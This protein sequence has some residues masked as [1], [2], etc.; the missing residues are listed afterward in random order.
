MNIIAIR[1]LPTR[2]NVDG[3]LQGRQDSKILPLCSEQ[4]LMIE[5]NLKKL[6]ELKPF[7]KVLVSSLRRTGM[8]ADCYGYEKEKE[9]EPLLDELD[10]GVHEGKPKRD[11]LSQIGEKWLASPDK[12]TLGEP[13]TNLQQRVEQLLCKYRKT[14]AI[15]IFGHAAWIRALI[16]FIKYG[17]I[18]EM[19]SFQVANNEACVIDYHAGA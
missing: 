8:T 18:R 9:V 15:L 5:T 13:L 3:F 11:M 6:N 4:A 10:F 12:L 19:N 1:H 16:C 7:E 14:N 17:D 2:A